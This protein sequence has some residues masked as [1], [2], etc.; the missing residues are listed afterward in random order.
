MLSWMKRLVIGR[1]LPTA[2]LAQQ[3]LGKPTALAVFASD[4]LSSSAYA[5][6][7]I[8]LVLV[9]VGA[10]ALWVSLPIAL[11]IGALLAIVTI[12]YRQTIQAYPGGGGAYIVARSNLGDYPGLVAAAG[13]LIGYVLTV[14][15]SVAAG[16]AAVISAFPGLI[17]YRVW[18]CVFAV[19]LIAVVNLRG[20]RE[21]G[22]IFAVPTY[23][24]ITAGLG[25]ILL[26]VVGYAWAEGVGGAAKAGPAAAAPLGAFLILRAFAS[27]CA[28]LTGIEAISDGVPAFRPPEAQNARVTLTW[29]SGILLT[30]FL[31]I[32]VLAYLFGVVPREEETVLSQL[33][34]LVFG[35]GPAYYFLQAATV[36]ILILAA[37]T[38]FADFPRLSYFLGRDRFMPRQLT[39]RGDRLVFSNGI[40]ILATLSSLLLILFKGDTHAIIP[41]YA[42]GVFLSFTLSQSGMVVRWLRLRQ[43]GWRRGVIVNGLGG[44]TTF[45]VLLILATTKFSQGAWIVLVLIPLVVSLFLAIHRHY[46][47]QREALSLKHYQMPEGITHRVVVPVAEINRGVLNALHYAR[48]IAKD[49]QI[50]GVTVAVE[51]GAVEELKVRWDLWAGG[52]PLVVLASPDR[53]LIRPIV[54]H[55]DE[56]QRKS[57]VDFVTVVIP[58][59]VPGKW[60]H[61]LLHNQSAL[62]IKAAFL[63]R[64]G[65]IVCNVPYHPER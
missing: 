39:N 56:V 43:P 60:W 19:G 45:V 8:L 51:E 29:M 36:L 27:G 26:G 65:T 18:L 49:G 37:N 62:L 17:R 54:A 55:V 3:R 63:F 16:I 44:A 47:M 4:A 10:A 64:R 30:L 22:R 48:S 59:F 23:L 1:P 46:T 2:H 25:L 38:A 9:G 21:S 50:E 61:H 24:F 14:S 33:G 7:E 32:T 52:I 58:E 53:S 41:L 12:S 6:E 13:L 57:G 15:V 11:A 40:L 34:R 28:A 35:E 31:G 42:L 5:T 20:V